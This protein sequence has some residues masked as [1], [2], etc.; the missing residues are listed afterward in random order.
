[1]KYKNNYKLKKENYK[2]LFT[3]SMKVF[4]VLIVI[5]IF[6]ATLVPI[7]IL[8]K[9]LGLKIKGFVYILAF[10]LWCFAIFFEIIFALIVLYYYRKKP[11]KR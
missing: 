2:I 1:M 6:I 9:T 8:L 7:A 4:G 11:E 10:G 5:G 3:E